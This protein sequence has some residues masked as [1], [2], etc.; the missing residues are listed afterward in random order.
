MA[1]YVYPKNRLEIVDGSL[2]P[3]ASVPE[4]LVVVVERAYSGPSDTIYIVQDLTEAKMLYGDKSPIINLA[5]RT[6]TG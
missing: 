2:L 5:N 1:G 4:D 6:R 3:I